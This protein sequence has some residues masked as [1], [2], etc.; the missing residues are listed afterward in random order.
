MRPSAAATQRMQKVRM[1]MVVI[2]L[3]EAIQYQSHPELAVKGTRPVE[4]FRKELARLRAM[5]LEPIP[6]L[7]FSTTHCTCR[8]PDIGAELNG[9]WWC[10]GELVSPEI[11]AVFRALFPG[12]RCPRGYEHNCCRP[13]LPLEEGSEV[14]E[15]K[16]I[17]PSLWFVDRDGY[18]SFHR[19]EPL[20]RMA[21]EDSVNLR[22]VAVSLRQSQ[23]ATQKKSPRRLAMPWLRSAARE[24]A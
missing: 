5:G 14:D 20:Y 11:A 2:D 13:L 22:S 3:G 7:N 1:N 6:K 23:L 17:N 8:T 4:K 12:W 19:Y 16:F 10:S 9:L 21:L 15:R 24:W 18:L